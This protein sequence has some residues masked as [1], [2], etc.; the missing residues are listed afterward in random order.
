MPKQRVFLSFIPDIS[1][2]NVLS[3]VQNILKDQFKE[4]SIKWEDPEKFHLT[5]RF[6]GDIEEDKVDA[7]TDTLGRLKFDFETIDFTNDKVDFFPNKRFPNIMF[8]GLKEKGNNTETLVSLID[9][10]IY[11]FG[12][13]PDKKFIPHITLARFNRNKRIRIE[14][15]FEYKMESMSIKF[16]SFYLMR[17]KLM[18]GGSEYE[19]ISKFNFNN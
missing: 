13:K 18:P 15:S 4:R 19:I 6:L 17:S 8:A 2:I 9:K 3:N 10:I 14:N 12:V 5:L 11:N 7:L 16:D 1:C